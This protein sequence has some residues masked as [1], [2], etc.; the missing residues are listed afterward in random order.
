MNKHLVLVLVFALLPSLA[1]AQSLGTPIKRTSTGV[2]VAN[3]SVTLAAKIVGRI[4]AIGY[5]EGDIVRSGEVLIDID[6][7]ELR[8]ELASARAA[9]NQEKVNLAHMKKLNERFRRLF[10]Q[11]S[12]S[13]DKADEAAFNYAA[14]RER[15]RRAQATVAKAEAVLRET[16]I[17]APFPGVI[18]ERHAELGQVTS[19]GEALLVLEDHSTL[20][21]KTSVKEKDVPHIEKG[22]R[23]LITIDAL[24]DLQIEATVSKVIP[25]GDANTHEFV[26]KAILPKREN[27]YPGMFGKAVFDQ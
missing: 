15:V 9:L 12:V 8:A 22:Q 25:S 7:A 19:P 4:E 16:K 24:G 27:L 11:K 20:E 26:V 17:K 18:I 1:G 21:F 13:A 14:A 6:D 10:K 3:R 5:E 2:V 23:V